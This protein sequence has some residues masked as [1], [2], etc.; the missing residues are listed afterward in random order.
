MTTLEYIALAISAI[1]LIAAL[2]AVLRGG[3]VRR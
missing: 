2:V 1:A 3:D